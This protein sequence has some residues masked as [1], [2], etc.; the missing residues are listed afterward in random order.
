M[1]DNLSASPPIRQEYPID[2]R[3][4]SEKH[5]LVSKAYQNHFADERKRLVVVEARTGNLIE[6]LRPTVRNW[7]IPN[8]NS[9]IN[10][11]GEMDNTLERE[12]SK[13]EAQMRAIREVSKNN[14]NKRHR[15]AIAS[16]FAMHLVRSESFASMQS[17]IL[18]D[19]TPDLVQSIAVEESV[20]DRFIQEKGR[21]P[22]EDELV[23]MAQKQ[24]DVMKTTRSG[25]IDSMVSQYHKI[26]EMLGTWR[27]Q[28]IDIRSEDLPGFLLP[29]VA[30][31][32]GDL[33]TPRFGFEA[34]LAVGDANLIIGPLTH[35]TL[36]CFTAGR[37][38]SITLKSKK[39]IGRV[40]SL[41]I[42]GA[43]SQVACHPNDQQFVQRLCRNL[44]DVRWPAV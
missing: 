14:I 23:I 39:Q 35:R 10:A 6:G 34:H 26:G 8:W 3:S 1:H 9:Y 5:H 2:E 20:V 11:L 33:K 25:L 22:H 29:D 30:I 37:E 43:R 40:N 17:K 15:R 19:H 31:V 21:S 28:L 18:K 13:I 44:P 4:T 12:W 36:A 38:Q 41:L 27:I 42:R 24:A 16:L 32:H 7:V